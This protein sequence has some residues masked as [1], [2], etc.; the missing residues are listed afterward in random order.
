MAVIPLSKE[1]ASFKLTGGF[2]PIA[3]IKLERG[4]CRESRVQMIPS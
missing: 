3:Q 2:C 4:R 1:K